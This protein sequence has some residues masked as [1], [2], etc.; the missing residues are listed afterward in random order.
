MRGRGPVAAIAAFL[1]G[2]P[3]GAHAVPLTVT[4]RATDTGEVWERDFGGR[5]FRS[6]LARA[7]EG[8]TERF[9]PFT[10]SLGLEVRDG[11][12]R[13]PVIAG[14]FGPLPLPRALLP[15]SIAAE[16]ADARGRFRFDVDL[17]AP[18]GL[19]RI[20]RYTGWLTPVAEEPALPPVAEGRL[21]QEDLRR[22]GRLR[23][24]LSR[25]DA[26]IGPEH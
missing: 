25:K 6:H 5:I 8:I 2:F 9:G 14:R 3:P 21:G 22:G 17:R 4:K 13:F 11:A 10:F 1:F 26:E 12:L 24:N 19:G 18:L 15:V 7:G 20:V 23:Q 16:T